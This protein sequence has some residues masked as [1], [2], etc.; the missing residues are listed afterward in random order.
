VQA[1]Q[2][3]GFKELFTHIVGDMAKAVRAR[4][5]ETEQ[6]Q[7]VRSQAAVHMMMG[8]L[9]RDVIE[10][11]LA[12]HCVMLHEVMTDSIRG[13]LS[14]EVDTMRR[15]TR[16]NIVALDKAFG[17]NLARLERYRLRPS[18]GS[19]DKTADVPAETENAAAPAKRTA[20]HAA[21]VEEARDIVAQVHAE[22]AFAA[23]AV[24]FIPSPEAIAACR[25]NPEAMAALDAGD[26]E[27]FARAMGVGRPSEAYL[28]AARGVV[29][30]RA[31]R[32]GPE[33]RPRAVRSGDDEAVR[34]IR[35]G[36]GQPGPG[37]SP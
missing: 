36:T 30:W 18:E 5:G 16:N 4:N 26:H 34:A 15:A 13:T 10:A 37:K 7:F 9:P 8:F 24:P 23:A 27:R 25:A 12:G 32:D 14:G 21:T 29:D 31:S 3:F 2:D 11:M 33:A 6:Q 19:R 22:P 35:E 1:H 17:N 20:G 28:A